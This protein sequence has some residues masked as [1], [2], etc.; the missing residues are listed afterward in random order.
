MIKRLSEVNKISDGYDFCVIGS[1]FAGAVAALELGKTG[2]KVLVLEA[3]V[4]Q[5]HYNSEEMFEEKECLMHPSLEMK[6]YEKDEFERKRDKSTWDGR[7]FYPLDRLRVKSLG[8]TSHIWGGNSGR[9]TPSDFRMFSEYGISVDWPIS[10]EEMED[11]YY[12][13]ELEMGVSTLDDN[14]FAPRAKETGYKLYPHSHASRI[15]I[16]R[17]ED[18]N[19]LTLHY[20][21]GNH[22]LAESIDGRAACENFNVCQACPIGALYTADIPIRK[23]EATG[24]VDFL[25][26]ANVSRLVEDQGLIRAAV[27]RDRKMREHRAEADYFIL[28]GGGVENARILLLSRNSGNPDG[29]SNRSKKVGKHFMEHLNIHV[30]GQI[31]EVTHAH[32][33]GWDRFTLASYQYVNHSQRGTAAGFEMLFGGVGVSPVKTAFR[34][35]GWGDSNKDFVLNNWENYNNWIQIEITFDML[36]YE[37]HVV[38]L[39]PNVKDIF[40]NPVPKIT[41]HG[42]REYENKGVDLAHSVAKKIFKHVGAKNVLL[43]RTGPGRRHHIGTTRMGDDPAM[44]VVDRTGKSH[45]LDNLYIVGSSVHPTAGTSGVTLTLVATTYWTIDHLLNRINV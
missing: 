24:N 35:P 20:F 4:K 25:I 41:Y 28:A 29:L 31:D 45:E 44:S 23:A 1:G 16:K 43:P 10:Y 7:M 34:E 21:S 11:Y 40:G 42:A 33:A 5:R 17:L 19:E 26:E 9:Y 32:S 14:P 15:W 30:R 37:D 27:V 39:D 18:Y 6:I 2:K 3:G 38:S 13:A 36:P 12:K 8:G 22:R